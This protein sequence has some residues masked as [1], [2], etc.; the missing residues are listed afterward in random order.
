MR[1]TLETNEHERGTGY[2]KINT[3]VLTE[4]SCHRPIKTGIRDIVSLKENAN[5]NTLWEIIKDTIRNIT[6]Q[7]TTEKNM[8]NMKRK[9]EIINEM[10]ILE[11]RNG[12]LLRSKAIHV[13][14]RN[15]EKRTTHKLTINGKEIIDI[16]SII[17]EEKN[18]MTNYS[19]RNPETKVIKLLYRH[20]T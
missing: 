4:E 11:N 13:E 14:K 1:L 2:F 19:K 7:F 16:H 18:T 6:T 17:N 5:P 10:E 8:N 3:S 15:Y 20:S 9:K 12:M